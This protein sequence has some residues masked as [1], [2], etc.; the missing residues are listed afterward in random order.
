MLH[1]LFRFNLRSGRKCLACLCPLH[2]YR[3]RNVVM[4]LYLA[5]YILQEHCLPSV[6]IVGTYSFWLQKC[7][8]FFSVNVTFGG[9]CCCC[10]YLF[11]SI[12]F[13]NGA[14]FLNSML[15]HH[16]SYITCSFTLLLLSMPYIF[17]WFFFALLRRKMKAYMPLL[18]SIIL[19]RILLSRSMAPIHVIQI[20]VKQHPILPYI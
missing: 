7:K 2:S 1:S 18:S 17:Q 9:G 10:W 8:L 12:S 14:Q 15:A 19:F 20:L 5:C 11:C 6:V 16:T 4:V 3:Q 13:E